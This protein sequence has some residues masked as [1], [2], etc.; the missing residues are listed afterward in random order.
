MSTLRKL[1][2]VGNPLRTLRSSLVLGPT[3]ALLKYLRSR[4][5][6]DEEAKSTAASSGNV[7]GVDVHDRIVMASRHAISSKALSMSELGL[8]TIPAVAWESNE[9][10]SLDLCKNK[11]KELPNELSLCTSLE[12][13]LLSDNK[14]EE[15]P[16]AVF[17]SLSN[18]RCLKLDRNP[19]HQ[20]PQGAFAALSTLH[21]FDFSGVSASLPEPPTLSD[22][23]ELQ[24]LYLRRM[25][26]REVPFDLMNLRHLRI[27]DLSQNSLSAIPESLQHLTC[28]EELDLS[29]NNISMLPPEL[30][31]LDPCLKTLKLDGNP[32]R[33]IR[34]SILDRGTKAVLQYL[35]DKLPA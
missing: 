35:K 9:V 22:M 17:A 3:Q 16:G 13:L 7:F 2:L 23:P 18:L 25:N 33:S 21:V 14:I 30:G 1:L 12:T 20:V 34:R 5:P 24:E 10:V 4:L 8:E 11:I 26:L 19:L 6:V 29:D 32:L 27:L 31:L 28:L 15:W